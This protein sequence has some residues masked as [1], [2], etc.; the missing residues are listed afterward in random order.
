MEKV[1][2]VIIGAGPAGLTSG[3]YASRA[4]LKTV[5]IESGP[6]GGK[7]NNTYH[8]ENY[9][10]IVQSKGYELAM[11]LMDQVK[12]FGGELISGEVIKISNLTSTKE[13]EVH[14]SNGKKFITKTIIIAVGM[15]AKKLDIP[16]YDKYFGKGVSVC[17]VC[18]GAFYR[19]KDIAVIG[20][21]NSATEESLFAANIVKK[22]YIINNFPTFKA[23]ETTLKKL[24]TLDNVELLTN[25]EIKSINGGDSRITSISVLDKNTNE[26]KDI[27]VSGVFTY[28]GWD[29]MSNFLKDTNL[30]DDSGFLTVN[31]NGETSIPGIYAAGDILTKTFKQITTAVSDGTNAAL[32]AKEYILK[33]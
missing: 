5:I 1:D 3:I 8:I 27:E 2:L 20:G 19:G 11:T 33:I 13:K 26:Q 29:P 16:G 17:V 14:L 4:G 23:E 15:S 28:I 22:L 6:P 9:P 7:L 18:D 25:T 24:D 12:N 21:G 31:K 32:S 10:G 30:L